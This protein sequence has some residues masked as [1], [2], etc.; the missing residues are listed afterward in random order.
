MIDR[1]DKVKKICERLQELG[2]SSENNIK[3]YGE[4][5]HLVSNPVP[6]G[7]GFAVD[8][9]TLTSGNVRRMRI[10]LPIIDSLRKE[11]DRAA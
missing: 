5:F 11:F 10:P 7:D 1:N 6:E 8:G 4:K 9:I 3:L 2:Y